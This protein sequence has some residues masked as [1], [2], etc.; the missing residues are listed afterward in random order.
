ML[1]CDVASLFLA[2]AGL[3]AFARLKILTPKLLDTLSSSVT[4]K[5]LDKGGPKVRFLGSEKTLK[6]LYKGQQLIGM[7]AYCARVFT[8]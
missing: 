8:M 5:L 6:M 2:Q 4:K 3:N 1:V 7:G